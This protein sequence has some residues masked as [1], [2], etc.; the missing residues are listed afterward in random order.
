MQHLHHGYC[1]HVQTACSQ[2]ASAEVL[3]LAVVGIFASL[4]GQQ[5]TQRWITGCPQLLDG[6]RLFMTSLLCSCSFSVSLLT[7]F[8]SLSLAVKLS[9]LMLCFT[10]VQS[11]CY[12]NVCKQTSTGRTN[13]MQ[14]SLPP[15]SFS[16][17]SLLSAVTA[18]TQHV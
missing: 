4:P 9:C 15:T 8:Q 13:K 10:A 6:H 17:V 1:F 7:E 11:L 2:K 14:L 3:M 18:G 5:R 16:H 12:F